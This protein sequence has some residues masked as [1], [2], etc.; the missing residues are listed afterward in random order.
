[1]D[2][3]RIY[4]EFIADRVAR[5]PDKAKQKGME[6]HHIVAKCLGGSNDESNLVNLTFSDHIFAHLLLEKI[7]GGKLAIAFQKMTTVPRYQ[8][9]HTRLAHAELREEANK[10][11]RFNRLGHKNGEKQKAAIKLYNLNRRGQPASPKLVE[12]RRRQALDRLG[13]P[14]HPKALEA[15]SRKGSE[16]SVPQKLRDLMACAKML[17]ARGLHEAAAGVSAKANLLAMHGE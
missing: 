6:R 16:R 11:K 17:A 12:A 4:A 7:H 15:I 5:H 8:G 1:M 10:T 9:R 3:L 14:A 13:K 2:Y